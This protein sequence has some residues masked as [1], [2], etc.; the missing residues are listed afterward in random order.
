MHIVNTLSRI[1]S[2]LGFLG[3]FEIFSALLVAI[4]CMGEFWIILNKLTRHVELLSKNASAFWRV[5]IWIDMVIRPIVVRLKIK[6]RKLPEAKEQLLER[7]FVMLVALGVGMEFIALMF[8]LHE[9]AK[10]NEAVSNR[11]TGNWANHVA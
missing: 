8:S 2:D 4:G 3:C 9:F 6:G 11:R 7:L 5:L 1:L 10:L